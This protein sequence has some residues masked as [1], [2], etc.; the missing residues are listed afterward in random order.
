MDENL[1]FDDEKSVLACH[2]SFIN[3]GIAQPYKLVDFMDFVL[4]ADGSYY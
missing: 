4:Y 2:A 1:K 3:L